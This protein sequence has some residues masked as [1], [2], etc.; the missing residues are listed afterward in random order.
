MGTLMT[1]E[2]EPDYEANT[3]ALD[4]AIIKYAA[5]NLNK[6]GTQLAWVVMV[7]R[8]RYD[9]DGSVWYSSA[10]AIRPDANMFTAAG[11]VHTESSRLLNYMRADD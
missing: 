3:A 1:E 7:A 4:A 9:E 11:L 10:Y 5:E 2:V 6:N 8:A